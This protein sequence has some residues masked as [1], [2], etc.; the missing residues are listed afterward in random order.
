MPPACDESCSSTI[1]LEVIPKPKPLNPERFYEGAEVEMGCRSAE[2]AQWAGQ[3]S[4]CEVV[5][6]ERWGFA[7]FT[8]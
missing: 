7:V 4:R 2:V 1:W 3:S 6:Q 8:E 5:L